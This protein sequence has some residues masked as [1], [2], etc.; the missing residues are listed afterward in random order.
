MTDTI[1]GL[2]EFDLAKVDKAV[3]PLF[4]KSDNNEKLTSIAT[5]ILFFL[6]C[7]CYHI[8]YIYKKE[9][10]NNNNNNKK[11]FVFVLF[12]HFLFSNKSNVLL[13]TVCNRILKE[14][15]DKSNIDTKLL[16]ELAN[17][18]I[19]VGSLAEKGGK[20][21]ILFFFFFFCEPKH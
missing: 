2:E 4:A 12:S 8:I 7:L 6:F 9:R 15:E 13:Q 16:G 14:F 11:K 3:S 17:T 18:F 10:D 19:I 21:F 5:V 20:K 1:D